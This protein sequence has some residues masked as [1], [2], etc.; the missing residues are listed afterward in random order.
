MDSKEYRQNMKLGIFVLA[1]ITLFFVSIFYIGSERNIFNKTFTVSAIFKN[2]EGLTEG[3]NVWL[4]GVKIGTVKNVT[5]ISEGKVVVNL[6]LKDKQNEFIKQD[7]TA[8]IGSDGLVGSKI[9]VVRPGSAA[10]S[11]HDNDTINSFSPTDTQE[12]I[13]IAKDVGSNTRSL[14]D[15]LK[16]ITAKINKGEGVVGELLNEGELSRD[17]RETIDALRLA[18]RNTNDATMDLKKLVAEVNGGDGLVTKLIR[19][20]SYAVTFSNALQNVAE[21]GVNAKAMS[22]DLK[23]VVSK[24]NDDDNAIG[25]LLADSTFA[26]KLRIT[27]DNA[28]SASIKLDQNMEAIRHNF[29]FR[30]YFKKQKKAQEKKLNN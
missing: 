25:V 8:F 22:E 29:L 26:H 14:T 16:L 1:G 19:D 13:N 2:V 21:V 12:L 5:I 23:E 27:L 24:F 17:L 6:S 28:Q 30:G 15:D 9:V 18:S 10:E 7:A 20:S 11:I 4:S 3:D